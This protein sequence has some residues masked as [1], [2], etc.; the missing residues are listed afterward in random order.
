[1]GNVKK[2]AISLPPDLAAAIGAAAES[3]GIS[4]SGW[5]AEAAARRLRR[6]AALRALADYEAEFGTIGE[7]E[8]EAVDQWLKSSLG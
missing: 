1:M 6:R 3:E 5:L 7:E 4:L 2:L 8:L